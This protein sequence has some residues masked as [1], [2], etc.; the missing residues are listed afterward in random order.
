[1]KYGRG[2]DTLEDRNN[3]LSNVISYYSVIATLI[4]LCETTLIT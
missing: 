4:S 3:S 2:L 1:M